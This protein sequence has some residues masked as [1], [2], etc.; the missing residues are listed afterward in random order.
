MVKYDAGKSVVYAVVDIV[1]ALPSR[2]ALP[3][4]FATKVA[5]VATRNR[6][7]FARFDIFREQALEF[8]I[9]AFGQFPKWLDSAVIPGGKSA[10]DIQQ[11]QIVAALTGFFKNSRRQIQGLHVVS[12]LVVWLPTWKLSPRRSIRHD[13]RPR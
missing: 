8:G 13:G 10:A 2:S 11:F 4:T 12:K 1:A 6:P 7:G 3:I 5:A 9:D